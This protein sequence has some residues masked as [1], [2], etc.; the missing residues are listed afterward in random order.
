MER[1]TESR[2]TETPITLEKRKETVY[3]P[4]ETAKRGWPRSHARNAL[5]PSSFFPLDE[6]AA[7]AAAARK[8][9]RDIRKGERQPSGSDLAFLVSRGGAASTASTPTLLPPPPSVHSRS[10]VVIAIL[11]D[12]RVSSSSRFHRV[13]LSLPKIR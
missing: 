1:P 10:S 8:R 2:L 5:D 9:E 13:S 11:G 7:A 6:A 3:D 12:D 4:K